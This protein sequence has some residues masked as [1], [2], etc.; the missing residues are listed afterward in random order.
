MKITIG[1]LIYHPM[2]KD[3]VYF[4]P[5]TIP[6]SAHPSYKRVT[7]KLMPASGGDPKVIA[8]LYGGQERLTFLRGRRTA[9]T[10]RL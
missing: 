8:Y 6:V 5:S 2:G 3:C 4:I 10:L 1:F 7:L 9:S